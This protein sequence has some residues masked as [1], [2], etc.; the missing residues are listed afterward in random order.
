[1]LSRGGRRGREERGGG[2]RD[3][4]KDGSEEGEDTDSGL[5][6][7]ET[8]RL[9]YKTVLF[10]QAFTSLLCVAHCVQ[11]LCHTWFN[12]WRHVDVFHTFEQL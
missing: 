7:N 4:G 8:S 10:V 12:T 5:T 2:G 11:F 6:I 1:M 3:A 9:Y